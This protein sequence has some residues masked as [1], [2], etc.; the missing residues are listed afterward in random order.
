MQVSSLSAS[1]AVLASLL[2][3]LASSGRLTGLLTACRCTEDDDLADA[4]WHCG[5]GRLR[6]ALMAQ[7]RHHPHGAPGQWRHACEPPPPPLP[8]PQCSQCGPKALV[9]GVRVLQ[10]SFIRPRSIEGAS[11]QALRMFPLRGGQP[12][13]K[14]PDSVTLGR[15]VRKGQNA[16]DGHSGLQGIV[17]GTYD[18]YLEGEDAVSKPED[19]LYIPED[20][21]LST[22]S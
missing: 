21:S 7:L 19:Q 17:G 11:A 22:T 2:Q 12:G 13:A 18:R 10:S 8:P 20:V 3:L 14:R 5:R 4:S 1:K 9:D 16:D 15:R 6:P